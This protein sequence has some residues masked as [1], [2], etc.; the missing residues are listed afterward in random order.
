MAKSQPE[1]KSEETFELT[2]MIDVV[3]L[4]LIYFMYLPI[5]Q[6]ADL[7]FSL[8]AYVTPQEQVALPN[9]IPIDIA[10]DGSLFVN[11]APMDNPESLDLPELTST[12]TRLKQSADR[13]KITTVV[14]IFPDMDAPHQSS[15]SVLNACAKAGIRQVSFAEAE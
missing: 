13:N 5:Q 8:P 4:L 6:E 12:L 3:F 10:P 9:E 7:K 15:I 11:G 2:S 1:W 14:T